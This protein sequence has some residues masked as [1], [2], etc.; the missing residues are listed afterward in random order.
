MNAHTSIP[1]AERWKS[2]PQHPLSRIVDMFET[3]QKIA[4]YSE[5]NP[6]AAEEIDDMVIAMEGEIERLRDLM[7]RRSAYLSDPD[8]S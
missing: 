8:N 6:D 2:D 7:W 5:Y 3:S 1:V 4:P